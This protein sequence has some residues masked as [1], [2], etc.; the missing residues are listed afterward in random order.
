MS[1]PRIELLWWEG[2]PSWP[3][4]L[5]ELRHAVADAGLDPARGEDGVVTV[6]GSTPAEVGAHAF[7]AGVELHELRAETTGL[8]DLYFRLTAGQ[9]QFAAGSPAPTPEGA[10]R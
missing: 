2:C 5:E 8:E 10:A 3:Q 6:T 1:H 7:A 9:E 4:A